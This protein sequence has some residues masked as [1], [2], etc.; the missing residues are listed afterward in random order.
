MN[1]TLGFFDLFTY[2]TVGSVYLIVAGY[3]AQRLSWIELSDVDTVNTTVLL[4]GLV[5]MSYLLGHI[6]FGLGRFIDHLIPRRKSRVAA[7]RERFTHRVSSDRAKRVAEVEPFLL[8]AAIEVYAKDAAVEVNR[9]R[10]VGLMLRNITPAIMLAAGVSLAE[11]IGG[12]RPAPAV[13]GSLLFT[14]GAWGLLWQGRRFGEWAVAKTFEI[15][16]WIAEIDGL[17]PGVAEHHAKHDSG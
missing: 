17:L 6:S 14:L 4:L 12:A 16:Y 7:A 2:T 8:L 1:F 15:S 13:A 11:F 3:A 9:L 5:V 10:A